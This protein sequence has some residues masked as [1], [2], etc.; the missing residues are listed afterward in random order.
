MSTGIPFL[1]QSLFYI[2]LLGISFFSKKRL[3]NEENK[4]YQTLIIIAIIEVIFEIILDFVGPMYQTIPFIS[5]LFAK[6]YCIMILC[7]IS[8][9]CLYI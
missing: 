5:Y 3:D 4:I 6:I 9:L 8:F 7:W 1:L 2:I